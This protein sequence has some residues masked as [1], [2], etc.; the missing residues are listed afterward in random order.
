[1]KIGNTPIYEQFFGKTPIKNIWLGNTKVWAHTYDYEISNINLV[2]SDGGTYL[3]CDG[4]N[5]MY[6]S[7]SLTKKKDTYIEGIYTKYMDITFTSDTMAKFCVS[8]GTNEYQFNVDEFGTE[9]MS[10][11][12]NP[13]TISITPSLYGITGDTLYPQIEP[14]LVE[15]I[16]FLRQESN[17][18]EYSN[19]KYLPYYTTSFNLT[20]YSNKVETYYYTSN[21]NKDVYTTVN[22]YL[23]DGERTLLASG[24]STSNLYTQDVEQNLGEYPILYS[25]VVSHLSGG[26]VADT[27]YEYEI[28][29]K[30]NKE[31]DCL[32]ALYDYQTKCTDGYY[33]YG[34]SY[35]KL[36]NDAHTEDIHY[37]FS[38]SIQ[39]FVIT[40]NN[41]II[42][43]D[44]ITSSM[45]EN[46]W[47]DIT[48]WTVDGREETI[49]IY[50]EYQ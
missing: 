27:D 18:A 38:S 40:Q 11:L 1:M 10:Y 12:S 26:T 36:L 5:K 43:I 4:S 39:E 32:L 3:K 45:T 44:G 9:D 23:F 49:T 16:Q 17:A 47:V 25:Y 2:Y 24:S 14:V 21:Q 35:L 30:T 15:S 33:G 28:M 13:F 22:S 37:S 42:T 7:C 48:A 31:Y 29:Q 46:E 20:Y 8:N 19:L 41:G 50:V 6:V 34:S